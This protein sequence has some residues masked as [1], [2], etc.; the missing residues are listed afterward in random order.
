[1]W[2]MPWGHMWWGWVFWLVIL[3]VIIW[4]VVTLVNRGNRQ[5][6]PS[7]ESRET[8]LDILKKRYA[9]GELSKEEFEEKKRDLQE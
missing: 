3:V 5:P 7:T 1:M 6:P 8:A 9:S 2:N 4:I